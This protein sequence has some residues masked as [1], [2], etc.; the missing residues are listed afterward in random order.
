MVENIEAG[1]VVAGGAAGGTGTG[2][3]GDV[4]SPLVSEVSGSGGLGDVGSPWV[5]EVDAGGTGGS[6]RAACCADGVACCNG[7]TGDGA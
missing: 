5:A 2:G 3:L 6:S 7:E 4:R 1:E